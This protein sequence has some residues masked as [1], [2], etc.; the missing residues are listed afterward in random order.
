[1][2]AGRMQRR[3]PVMGTERSIGL[4]EMNADGLFLKAEID[5]HLVPVHAPG[6]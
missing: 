5:G 1:M 4:A 2:K 6:A 3:N